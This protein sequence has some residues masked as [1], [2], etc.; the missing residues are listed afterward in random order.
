L[1]V[2]VHTLAPE[3]SLQRGAYKDATEGRYDEAR[4]KWAAVALLY[5][6]KGNHKYAKDCEDA[7]KRPDDQMLRYQV[8]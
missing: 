8:A 6:A 3:I 4:A 2:V 7:A 1:F 5:H